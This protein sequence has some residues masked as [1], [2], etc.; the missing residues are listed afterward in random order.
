MKVVILDDY[1][2][3]VRHLD[4][5][6]KLAGHEVTIYNDTVKDLDALVERLREAEAVVLIRERTPITAPLLERLPR[7]QLI[8]QTARGIAHIDL[9]AC[10][11]HGVVVAAG[12]GSPYATAELTWG[13]ILAGMRHIPLE[14]LRL[15]EGRWQTTLGRGLRG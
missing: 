2:D 12:G 11:R 13:L 6:S 8:S 5:F 4:C 7:L 14:F 9:E 3:A 10:T 15:R 1:Q